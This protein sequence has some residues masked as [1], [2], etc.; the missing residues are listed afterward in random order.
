MAD[1]E[2]FPCPSCQQDLLLDEDTAG[3]EITCPYCEARV[4][5]PSLKILQ[6]A[7]VA[8]KPILP[9]KRK[10]SE[11]LASEAEQLAF[12]LELPL[13]PPDSKQKNF[14]LHQSRPIAEPPPVANSEPRAT[15]P[16]G[17]GKSREEELRR[18]AAM[19]N[20]VDYDPKTYERDGRLTFGCPLCRY[21]LSIAKSEVGRAIQ[22]EGCQTNLIAPRPE[23]GLP[24]QVADMAD[25]APAHTGSKTIIP[26]VR[27]VDDQTL[28]EGRAGGRAKRA[29]DADGK[30][31]KA[32]RPSLKLEPVPAKPDERIS[33]SAVV[34]PSER[35]SVARTP[36]AKKSTPPPTAPSEPSP[37]AALPEPSPEPAG[38]KARGA[39]RLN[40]ERRVFAPQK[41]LETDLEV[42]ESW[43]QAETKPPVSRRYVIIAWLVMIPVL[44]GFLL[45]GMKEV[46]RKKP[47]EDLTTQK[48]SGS[49]IN[50]ARVVHVATDILKSFYAAKSVEEMARYVRHPDKTLPRMEE[51]YRNKRPL[52]RYK[53]ESFEDAQVGN[54]EGVEFLTGILTLE[55]EKPRSVALE[56]PLEDN[57]NQDDLRI[58]WES[59][60]YYAETPWDQFLSSQ[61]E[62]GCDFRVV[63]Q[64]DEYWVEPYDDQSRWICFKLYNPGT[65]G[66]EYGYC[67]G[68]VEVDTATATEMILPMRRAAEKGQTSVNAMVRLRF[69]PEARGRK[70]FVPQV[71]IE[72]FRSGW[73]M[74]HE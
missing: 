19:A 8:T 24:A 5:M 72:K 21:S 10:R 53:V 70:N 35:N 48:K 67:F 36:G 60:V 43:G 44:L 9:T 74:P 59:M 64:K 29:A 6:A 38:A 33:G 58:D 4:L 37:P 49:D 51:Y 73:L 11:E 30:P 61:S 66:E 26:S 57:P 12:D 28:Q 23:L 54:L 34:L 41:D 13:L 47:V 22:C 7:P 3:R 69:R 16:P 15:L 17:K 27:V 50:E 63:L 62:K 25:P 52:V 32:G 40:N 31:Q 55:G 45:W 14:P 71:T 18:L 42:T 56:L 2:F 68:Y 65:V 46:F 39:V 1:S 20:T